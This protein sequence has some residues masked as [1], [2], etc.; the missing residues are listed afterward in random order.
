[1]WINAKISDAR[2]FP[3]L[4]SRAKALWGVSRD[5]F[6]ICA[7][8]AI[9]RSVFLPIDSEEDLLP[10]Y[11]YNWLL[12]RRLIQCIQSYTI[13]SRLIQCIAPLVRDVHSNSLICMVY[14]RHHLYKDVWLHLCVKGW[15]LPLL[16]RYI[17]SVQL[18]MLFNS[19]L[20]CF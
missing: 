5:H 4:P 12:F 18:Q 14:M 11:S 17:F 6:K 2:A 3:I 20:L 15:Q 16:F 7:N 9:H 10:F 1:M 8:T 13:S 19:R